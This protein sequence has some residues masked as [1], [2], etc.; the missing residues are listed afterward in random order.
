MFPQLPAISQLG[1]YV[2]NRVAVSPA[3]MVVCFRQ[4]TQSVDFLRLGENQGWVFE[5]SF[6]W[7]F[8]I[9]FVS[10]P[11]QWLPLH[12]WF[13]GPMLFLLLF[14]YHFDRIIQW[15][16]DL[17]LM[18]PFR[19]RGT[20]LLWPFYCF[21]QCFLHFPPCPL[22]FRFCFWDNNNVKTGGS[23]EVLK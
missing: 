12:L 22:S 5:I 23:S 7:P 21:V 16:W 11:D 3:Q 13:L 2:Y 17:L 14:V 10:P 18:P 15:L 9:H 4:S 19:R 6:F 20:S 8:S 1:G